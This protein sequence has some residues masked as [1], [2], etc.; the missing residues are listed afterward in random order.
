MGEIKIKN[1]SFT[2]PGEHRAAIDNIS[3]EISRGEFVCICGK[4]GCG[5]TTLLR[6]LKPAIAP[7]GDKKGEILFDGVSVD[8]INAKEQAAKTGFVMQNPDSQ[9][10]TDK[11]WHELAFG[12]ESIGMKSDEIRVRVAEMAA[13]FGIESWFYKN[14]C[15]LSGGQKQLLNLASVMVMH[16]SV[17]ILDEPLSQLDPIAAGEFLNMLYKINRELSVTVILSEHRL[18]EVLPLSDRVIIMDE[19]AI[20]AQETPGRVGAFLKGHDM[21]RAMP[22]VMRMHGSITTDDECPV[23]LREGR[24]WLHK[25]AEQGRINTNIVFEDNDAPGG[26]VCAEIRGAYFSYGRDLPD[27]IRG[28]DLTLHRGEMLAILGGNGAGKSTALSLLAGLK[29]PYRGKVIIKKEETAL[30]P[31]NVQNLFTEKSVYADLE[32]VLTG[33]SADEK[34]QRIYSVARLCEIEGLLYAHPF[35]LSGGEQQR[36]ALAKVLLTKPR[37]LLL[38][39]PTKGMDAAFKEQLAGILGGLCRQGTSVI[40]VS[41]D[42]EFCACHAHRCAL[43]FDGKIAAEGTPRQLFGG[44]SFYTTS[45]AKMAGDII[46]GA[47]LPQDVIKA[48]GGREEEPPKPDLPKGGDKPS[49]G[50]KQQQ[51]DKSEK[52]RG[53]KITKSMV[54]ALLVIALIVPFTIYAGLRFFGDRKYLFISL[55]IIF[56]TLIPFAFVFEKRKPKAREIVLISVLCAIAVAGRGAFFMLPQFKPMAAII[57][58]SGICFGGETGFLVGAVSAFVSNFL[59]G[60]GSWAPWQMFAFGVIGFISGVVFSGVILPKNRVV[61]SVYGFVITLVIYGGIMN[62]ASVIMWQTPTV[63]K[64]IASYA[65]GLPFDLMHGVATAVFMWF[66]SEPMVE[67]IMRVRRKFGV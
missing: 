34:K 14:T 33:L 23:S 9:L 57:I 39:G 41:H 48:M 7:F 10:V 35:D 1:L 18:E 16:P 20:Y 43:F 24:A 8:G 30:L 62:P 64:I 44:N 5:K 55:L 50:T 25:M 36:A 63:E 40:M 2:Y 17:L 26:E 31:Q 66:I 46:K 65:A 22:S 29:K 59:F 13:F 32:S 42:I 58:I 21:M 12:L 67:K 54:L 27:V 15:D 6:L 53:N 60:Q 51:T 11:V 3:L 49:A 56:E 38:D 4:S 52:I 19:G 28:L 61:L 37:I 45:T 47:L